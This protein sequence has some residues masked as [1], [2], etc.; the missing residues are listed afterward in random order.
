[1]RLFLLLALVACRPPPGAGETR[2]TTE[3]NFFGQLE[4]NCQSGPTVVQVEGQP[5][6]Y[7]QPP[8]PSGWWCSSRG[9][10]YSQCYRMYA[11]CDQWRTDGN[12]RRDG[13][14]YYECA[15][16]GAAYCAGMCSADMAGCS[17]MEQL[18]GRDGAAC[19][20]TP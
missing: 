18:L 15:H 14:E 8:P 13:L 12:K 7:G 16:I 11:Q 20:V 9:D 19:V 3:R 1:M 4:T 5:A 2:C 10:G 6:A 17:R